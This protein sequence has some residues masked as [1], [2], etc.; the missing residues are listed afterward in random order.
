MAAE[1]VPHRFERLPDEVMRARSEAFLEALR[2]RR[3]IRAYSTEPVPLDV[4]ENA[5]AAAATAPSGAN[6]QP[7][8]FVVVTEPELKRRIRAAAEEEERRSYGGRM[9]EEW[10]RAIEPFGTDEHKPHLEDAPVVIAV[11]EQAY[12]RSGSGE[13][14][15]HYYVR[16]SVGIA[17]GFLIAA[18]NDAGLASLVHTPSPMGFLR[19][20]LGRPENERAYV[21]LAVGYPAE[22]ATVPVIDKKPLDEVLVRR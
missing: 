22:E 3:T 14:V 2:R 19:E 21:L 6:Q 17:V 15:K 5:V 1:F 12:G 8:T 13:K 4:V 18:L 10:L 9:P 11:F 20:I 7:W 16:E